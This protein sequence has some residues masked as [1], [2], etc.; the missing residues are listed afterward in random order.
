MPFK[1]GLPVLLVFTTLHWMLSQSVFV[2]RV[3]SY[4]ANGEE[5]T[6]SNVSATGYSPISI[7][8]SSSP[9]PAFSQLPR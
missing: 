7:I 4:Y 5:D 3:I 6:G 9:Y 2:I 8:T 1:Y